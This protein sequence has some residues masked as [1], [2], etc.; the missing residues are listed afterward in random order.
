[1]CPCLY[2]TG[3]RLDKNGVKT[4]QRAHSWFLGILRTPGFQTE[5]ARA[6]EAKWAGKSKRLAKLD[7]QNFS[8]VVYEPVTLPRGMDD[9]PI[10]LICPPDPLHYVKLG[11]NIFNTHNFLIFFPKNIFPAQTQFECVLWPHYILH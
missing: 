3:Y 8:S 10:L 9:I 5:R 4:H 1:M 2:C 11:K 6:H 7:R